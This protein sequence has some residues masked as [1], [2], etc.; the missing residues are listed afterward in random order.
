M[1]NIVLPLRQGSAQNTKETLY[2]AI[3]I[4]Q[5]YCL[6]RPDIRF[7]KGTDRYIALVHQWQAMLVILAISRF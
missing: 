5:G 2:R 4:E 6:W 3:T 1:N 7:K